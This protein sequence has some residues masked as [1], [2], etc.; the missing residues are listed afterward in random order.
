MESLN[1]WSSSLL[2]AMTTLGAKIAGFIPNLLAFV[3]ILVVG[4]FVSKIVAGVLRRVLAAIQ[5]DRVSEK[6]GI[7][8]GLKR[9]NIEHEF[10]YLLSRVVFWILMLTFL[11]SAT[12]S[13][14]LPRV[15]GTIDAFVLYLPNI[16][17]A[18]AILLLGLLVAG[19]A[20]DVTVNSAQSIGLENATP[21]GTAVQLLLGV[22]VISLT[23]SQLELETEIL[24]QVISILLFSAGAAAAIAFGLGSRGIASNVLASTYVRELFQEGQQIRIADTVGKIERITSV[25][26]E[27]RLD[28]GSLISLPNKRLL[29]SPVEQL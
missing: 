6:V 22:V 8:S 26:T 5:V 9:A 17:G 19:V 27:I 7:A 13:L 12:E 21:L 23:I 4:Y 3:V 25:K 20:R 1:V 16:L 29:E 14:G 2:A 18:A 28:S 11:V 15:S 10:S 24:N